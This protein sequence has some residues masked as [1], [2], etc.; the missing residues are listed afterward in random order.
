MN[1]KSVPSVNDARTIAYA[2]RGVAMAVETVYR[3]RSYLF[4]EMNREL[5]NELTYV[6]RKYATDLETDAAKDEARNE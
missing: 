5:I 3:D 1:D 4:S 6:L 2:L